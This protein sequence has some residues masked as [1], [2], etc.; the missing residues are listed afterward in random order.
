MRETLE[1][2]RTPNGD[3]EEIDVTA[4]AVFR[5]DATYSAN[6]GAVFLTVEDNNLRYRI[7]GGNPDANSGHLVYAG[8]N[9]WFTDPRSIQYLRMIGD[10]G[11]A[12]VIVTY[13]HFIR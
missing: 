12:R 7:D 6:A 8:Q 1:I 13:Y 10:G 3:Y 5:L 4:A 9:I 11:T 2:G